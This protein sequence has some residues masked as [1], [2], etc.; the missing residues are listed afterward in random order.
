MVVFFLS[1][2]FLALEP[3]NTP[4]LSLSLAVSLLSILCKLVSKERREIELGC[5]AET[6]R[7]PRS[8][9]EGASRRCS[10]SSSDSGDRGASGDFGESWLRSGEVTAGLRSNAMAL[11]RGGAENRL[12]GNGGKARVVAVDC[13]W[14]SPAENALACSATTQFAGAKTSL[15]PLRW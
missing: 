5:A 12:L 6:A 8:W 1:P 2:G 9:L 15:F 13:S 3:P 14:I 7:F 10:R 4:E 11:D